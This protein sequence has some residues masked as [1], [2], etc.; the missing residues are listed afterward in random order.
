LTAPE[1]EKQKE[2]TQQYLHQHF[3]VSIDIEIDIDID[4]YDIFYTQKELTVENTHTQYK[5]KS[6]FT[7]HSIV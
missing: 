3:L 6:H 4:I 2:S 1:P 7:M 5:R